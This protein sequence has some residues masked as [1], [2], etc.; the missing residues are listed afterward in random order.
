M[1]GDDD[2]TLLRREPFKSGHGG[3]GIEA[4][5]FRL[6]EPK[7][8][9]GGR[10]FPSQPPSGHLSFIEGTITNHPVEPRNGVLRQ[11]ALADQL[12]KRLL[13][14]VFRRITLLPAYSTSGAE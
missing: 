14:D 8:R 12:D 9:P 3:F 4:V 13:N 2:L 6:D 7:D 5:D 10:R 11:P 1:A